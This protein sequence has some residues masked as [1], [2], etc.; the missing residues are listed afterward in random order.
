MKRIGMIVYIAGALLVFSKPSFGTAGNEYAFVDTVYNRLVQAI[1]DKSR[2]SPRLLLVPDKKNV[3]SFYA[4]DRNTI[5]LEIPA[6]QICRAMG[7]DSAN[8]VAFLLAHELGHY[9]RNH[10][11]LKEASSSY[12]SLDI[13]EKL[14]D[15]KVSLDTTI[16]NETEADEFACYYSKMAGYS[17]S[18]AD[19][20]VRQFYKGY[21]LPDSLFRYP[22]LNDRCGI[23]REVQGRM[24]QLYELFNL[25]NVLLLHEDYTTA[26]ILYKIILNKKFG[27]REVKNN[28]GVC[29]AMQGLK[30][31]N[32]V[33]QNMVFPF[34][35]D[36]ASRAAEPSR[37][38]ASQDSAE[39]KFFFEEADRCFADAAAL[40]KD[41]YPARINS[42]VMRAVLGKAKS[43]MGQLAVMEEVFEGNTIIQDELIYTRALIEYI[44]TGDT[45][46]MKVLAAKGEERAIRNMIRLE[47][48]ALETFPGNR[49]HIASGLTEI[50]SAIRKSSFKQEQQVELRVENKKLL[51]FRRDS[52]D[53]ELI[54]VNVQKPSSKVV[55]LLKSRSDNLWSGDELEAFSRSVPDQRHQFGAVTIVKRRTNTLNY[56][57]FYRDGIEEFLYVVY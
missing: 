35:L 44:A 54:L 25:A 33:W 30:K 37:S 10:G 12:A 4:G 29:M 51:L 3:A 8:A 48:P 41:Y 24:E 38:V 47:N 7:R 1:G 26:E 20:F 36:P 17:I 14:A 21:Q 45:S 56:Y 5:E 2:P 52:I 11:F 31:V 42:A 34:M 39:A 16:K 46:R 57:S 27:S 23:A 53:K 19:K 9:Y 18:G 50:Q 55:Q 49:F 32:A 28:L 6:I 40:D 43:A 15:V 22:S 13:G